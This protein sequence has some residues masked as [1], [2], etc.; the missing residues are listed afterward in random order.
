MTTYIDGGSTRIFWIAMAIGIPLIIGA[1]LS[2]THDH[3]EAQKLHDAASCSEFSQMKLSE[4]PA[5]CITPQ[6]G[7]KS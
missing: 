7:F 3:A 6:G 4:I 1:V 5:R 2:S